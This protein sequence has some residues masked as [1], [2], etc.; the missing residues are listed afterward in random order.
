K[1]SS[2]EK[3]P[4]IGIRL[5]GYEIFQS[6]KSL[7]TWYRNALYLP[8]VKY[9]NR[10]ADFIYS[11]GGGIT[12]IIQKNIQGS[13]NKIIEVPAGI[14]K[15]WIWESNIKI[16]SPVRFAFVGRYDVRKGVKELS[17]ALKRMI[18]KNSFEFHFI[19]PIPDEFKI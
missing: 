5:H 12:D 9:L 6:S 4:P 7:L 1:K 17:D 14:E 8:L 2:G 3:L 18:G 15:E 19:G 16:N 13:Q 10:N 11:Y